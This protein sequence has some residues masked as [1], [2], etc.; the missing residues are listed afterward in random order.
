MVFYRKQRYVD[1][2]SVSRLF[3]TI[4]NNI[5]IEDRKLNN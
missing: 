2:I 3:R 5:N 1:E 4:L